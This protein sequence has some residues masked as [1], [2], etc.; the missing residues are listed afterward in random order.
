MMEIK[1]AA[2]DCLSTAQEIEAEFK[3]WLEYSSTLHAACV[4]ENAST[5]DILDKNE[6]DKLSEEGRRDAQKITVDETKKAQEKMGSA[7]DEA[8]KAFKKASDE[9]PSG[10]V[11]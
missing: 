11:I 6:A 1:D 4:D 2:H 9:F 10:Y 7:L 8:S 3:K 5:E